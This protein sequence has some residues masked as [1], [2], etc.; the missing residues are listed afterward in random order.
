MNIFKEGLIEE[1]LV[2]FMEIYIV[3]HC[4]REV[5]EVLVG[6]RPVIA[7]QLPADVLIVRCDDSH[8]K[9]SEQ[10]SFM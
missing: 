3:K 5:I 4:L 8:E 2:S 7:V 9:L 1:E 6:D 10:S